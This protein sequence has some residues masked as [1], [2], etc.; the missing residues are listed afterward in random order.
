M[1]ILGIDPGYERLGIAV[2][3][4]VKE[5][6]KQKLIFSECFQTSTKDSHPQRL[7]QIQKEVERII[8]KYKPNKLAI[9]TL[10]FNK[11]VNI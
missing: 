10:F 3:E 5:K 4:K 9:E 11:N 1:K 2:L 7:S 8:K 6:E